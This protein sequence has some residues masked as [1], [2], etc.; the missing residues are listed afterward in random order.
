MA[1]QEDLA[2]QILAKLT[3]KLQARHTSGSLLTLERVGGMPG[4][5]GA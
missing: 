2:Y 3:H 4:S 1:Q 5:S